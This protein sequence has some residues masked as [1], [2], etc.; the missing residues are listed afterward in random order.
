MKDNRFFIVEGGIQTGF[1]TYESDRDEAFKKYFVN[2]DRTGFK[3]PI[4]K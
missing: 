1:F 3:D 4:T 2:T